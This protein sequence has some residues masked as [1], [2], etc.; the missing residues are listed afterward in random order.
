MENT[1]PRQV[2]IAEVAADWRDPDHPPRERAV[3]ATLDAPNRWT[4]GALDHAL[5][6]WMQR[7]TVEALDR[8]V[9]APE[10][11]D[12]VHVGVLHGDADPLEGIRDAG[13]VWTSGHPYLGR[14][15]EASPALLPA[16]AEEVADRASGVSASFGSRDEVLEHADALM[17]QPDRKDAG[18]L[19]E[20][21]DAHGI[22]EPRRL[23]RPPL[24]TIGVLDGHETNG[25]CDRLAE[26]LLLYEGGGHR[27]LA[28][29]WAPCDLSPDPYLEAM[30]RF[31]GAFPV[32]PDTPGALQMPKAFLEAHDESHAYAEGLEF[33]VSR[34]DPEPQSPGHIRW[35]EYDDFDEIGSWIQDHAESLY[36]VVARDPLHDQ[37]PDDWPLRTPGGLHVPPLDDAEGTAIAEFVRALS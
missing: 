7:F 33:L 11:A 21:C 22:P 26:D 31:R 14:V 36:T 37:L 9:T 16:F 27:R 24:Y 28:V 6:R 34:G 23:I 29:L 8:W 3:E 15:P 1:P 12:P 18:R 25:D 17:A 20:D 4:E 2:A 19:R 13:A 32:H 30:A 10:A 5:N 35:S